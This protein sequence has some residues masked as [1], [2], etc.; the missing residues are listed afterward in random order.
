ML[1]LKE[2]PFRRLLS[3][4]EIDN[5]AVHGGTS[6]QKFEQC[7]EHPQ[8]TK[9]LSQIVSSIP[10]DYTAELDGFRLVKAASYTG[11][12]A[13]LFEKRDDD[14]HLEWKLM[15]ANEQ[16]S[17]TGM[18][19]A[20]LIG[21][22]P[23][24]QVVV[25][26]SGDQGTSVCICDGKRFIKERCNDPRAVKAY[27]PT[28]SEDY[29]ARSLYVVEVNGLLLV[30]GNLYEPNATTKPISQWQQVRIHP[31]FQTLDIDHGELKFLGGYSTDPVVP[32]ERIF[33]P[34][35]QAS[36]AAHVGK[37]TAQTE[38]GEIVI[39]E[40]YYSDHSSFSFVPTNIVATSGLAQLC[41]RIVGDEWI[42]FQEGIPRGGACIDSTGRFVNPKVSGSSTRAI[43]GINREVAELDP[44]SAS[45]LRTTIAALT[46]GRT[47]LKYPSRELS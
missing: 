14:G 25:V 16:V 9:Y 2:S 6:G 43:D 42:A 37:V 3:L 22:G 19:E 17:F 33:C 20:L 34:L 12:F 7:H 32:D 27:F 46:N 1:G 47:D 8:A 35:H 21:L 36:I 30:N 4:I 11:N 28:E 10:S 31:K 23:Q 38:S 5:Q 40:M 15:T 41:Q 26:G 18:E 13:L 39:G 45:A 29:Y 44:V 24:K